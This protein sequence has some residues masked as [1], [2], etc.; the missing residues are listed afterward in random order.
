LDTLENSATAD[1][2]TLRR[3][4]PQL[5]HLEKRLLGASKESQEKS[6]LALLGPVGDYGKFHIQV[7]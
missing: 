1:A 2:K 7:N 5:C 4:Q 6:V 3:K